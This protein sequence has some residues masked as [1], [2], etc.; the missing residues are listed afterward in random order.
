MKLFAALAFAS[1]LGLGALA[2]TPAEARHFDHGYGY[3]Q[4]RYCQCYFPAR[5]RFA[6][7]RPGGFHRPY[8]PFGGYAEYRPRCRF[9]Y[10]WRWGTVRRI[11]G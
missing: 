7:P 10:D 5:C 8:P 4:G 9:V 2:A 3:G 11:C 6:C 1:T